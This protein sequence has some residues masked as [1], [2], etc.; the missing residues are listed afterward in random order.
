M[1]LHPPHTPGRILWLPPPPP[2]PQP[3]SYPPPDLP[4]PVPPPTPTLPHT[5]P[6]P[7]PTSVPPP[8]SHLLILLPTDCTNGD[9]LRK[10]TWCLSASKHHGLVGGDRDHHPLPGAGGAGQGGAYGGMRY[11]A[12]GMGYEAWGMDVWGKGYGV[13]PVWGMGYGDGVTVGSS[14][15]GRAAGDRAQAAPCCQ[16]TCSGLPTER[17]TA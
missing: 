9:E 12:R 1:S 10:C 11:G 5:P 8:R 6:R 14:G 15:A 17:L 2:P 4:Q 7:A 13:W 16:P 3:T